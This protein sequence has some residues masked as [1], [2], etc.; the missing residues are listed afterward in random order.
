MYVPSYLFV[1]IMWYI[2]GVGVTQHV[3]CRPTT[4]TGTIILLLLCADPKC[5][6]YGRCAPGTQTHSS[7]VQNLKPILACYIFYF[8]CNR[9][10][11]RRR[12]FLVD[13]FFSF[14]PPPQAAPTLSVPSYIATALFTKS[15]PPIAGPSPPKSLYI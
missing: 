10:R 9:R 5:H 15:S 11:R 4:T 3:F 14:S 13:L 2:L 6:E 1:S 8:N 12:F 7:H